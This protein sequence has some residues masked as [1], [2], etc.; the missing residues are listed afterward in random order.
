MQFSLSACMAS[1]VPRPSTS[2]SM[3]IM[4]STVMQAIEAWWKLGLEELFF[5]FHPIILDDALAKFVKYNHFCTKKMNNC[6]CCHFLF[7]FTYCESRP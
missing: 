5:F 6:M 2:F 7:R 4:C 1:I 3:A